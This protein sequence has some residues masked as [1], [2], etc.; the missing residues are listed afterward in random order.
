MIFCN[1]YK[2]LMS[3][4]NIFTQ[5]LNGNSCLHCFRGLAFHLCVS[6][7]THFLQV[8]PSCHQGKE[9]REEEEMEQE[10]GEKQV[11]DFLRCSQD[12]DM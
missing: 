12:S 7:F 6:T 4:I 9:Q 2:I 3:L 1:P 8:P 11:S 10:G 5:F